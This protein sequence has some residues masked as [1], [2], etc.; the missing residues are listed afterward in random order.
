MRCK[1]LLFGLLFFLMT[2]A[3]SA[4]T[5]VVSTVADTV[6]NDGECSLRE[7]MLNVEAGNQSGSTDCPAGDPGG[8]VI[9]FS[10]ELIGQTIVLSGQPLPTITQKLD[11]LGPESGNPGGL[12]IDAGH[13]SRHFQFQ[14]AE[15]IGLSDLTL[16]N[17]RGL[18]HQRGGSVLIEDG[19][20][21]NFNRVHWLNNATAGELGRGG[22]VAV[23][24]AQAHF[25][26]SV[27]SNNQSVGD[28]GAVYASESALFFEQ[29]Q[30]I[31][32]S[33]SGSSA[34][35]G[36]IWL[37]DGSLVFTHGAI[38]D[39]TVLGAGGGVFA[40]DSTLSISDALVAGNSS[41]NMGGGM[42][43]DAVALDISNTTI[44]G[45]QA[46]S[47]SAGLWVNANSTGQITN[48][49]LSGNSSSGGAGT[50]IRVINSSIDLVHVTVALNENSS[51]NPIDVS[52]STNSG[53][54]SQLR[55]INS[56]LL[57][58]RCSGTGAILINIG[59]MASGSG[60]GSPPLPGTLFALAPLADNGGFAN[61]HALA[62]GSVAIAQGGD[63]VQDWGVN[64]DQRG[65]ARPGLAGRACDV[66]AYESTLPANVADLALS[67]DP[68][69]T[70]IQLGQAATF[71]IEVEQAGP[72]AAIDIDVAIT[73][74][75]G[76]SFSSAS[77][78]SGAY[79]AVTGVWRMD[80]LAAGDL[81]TLSLVANGQA[82]GDQTLAAEVNASTPDPEPANNTASAT[83]E[84][85]PAPVALVVTTLDDQVI[86]DGACSLR[87]AILQITDGEP[88]AL[89]DCAPGNL[90]GHLAEIRFAPALAEGVIT[91]N[92]T[93]LP[94][95]STGI[96]I[97]GPLPED[98]RGITLDAGGQS[99]IFEAVGNHN[100][101]LVGMTL[102]GGRV[103]GGNEHGG[104]IRVEQGASLRM[105]HA[106]LLNSE[107]SGN[108]SGGGALAA[109]NGVIN[110]F[111]CELTDNTSVQGD[112]G[113]IFAEA[114][115]LNLVR[116]LLTNNKAGSGRG[117]AVYADNEDRFTY[118]E[119]TTVSRNLS[120]LDGG[121]L[122]AIG[123]LFITFS[124]LYSN[125]AGV[126]AQ[127]L[128]VQKLQPVAFDT[129]YIWHS[130]I[131]QEFPGIDSCTVI[132]ATLDVQSSLSTD[133]ACTGL[134]SS[135][136]EIGLQPL[137]DNGGPTRTH[138]LAPD[139]IAVNM[140]D[141]DCSGYVSV[142]WPFHD[143]R[144][145]QRPGI[146]STT[147]DAGA[148]ERQVLPVDQIFT[149]RFAAP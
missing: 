45:N 51:P 54:T 70:D 35:G 39:N 22:A 69:V 97:E 111:D 36:G 121:G 129:L 3:A 102:T 140:G 104:A 127:D 120:G 103:E 74:P 24:N 138:A 4:A 142:G 123:E 38:S 16:I 7:A 61:T 116:C 118:L 92:G 67:V 117:G 100:V 9:E 88:S 101:T 12:T 90:F 42:R 64:Q 96:R 107:A 84:V 47:Q 94:V 144:N 133:A 112:G 136:A 58:N 93:A 89:N 20:S 59:S 44:S 43:L 2:S 53:G 1:V 27:L 52:V 85:W 130:L 83:I 75:A 33:T 113:A 149:D 31:G 8:S 26:Q 68:S 76:L 128:F 77:A 109:I 46:G 91:M 30:V 40:E 81:A 86:E 98:A 87:E 66:G 73:L 25:N 29:S 50:A 95:L 10:A 19:A 79:D 41:G 6:A 13:Q 114:S 143:Q 148:Y 80:A 32:N 18:N 15:I 23:V 119:N 146:G 132:N 48:S 137:A 78:S 5:L 134:A 82:V 106:R 108:G 126:G 56:L 105:E 125:L 122:Y 55:L 17:G 71:L 99:R 65:Q 11:I 110:L 14:Q 21:V 49:T 147:C 139:S 57:V 131:V 34:R 63:C 72:Q 60:C 115:N 135:A 37:T 62:A 28:G 124:T 145:E 141:P